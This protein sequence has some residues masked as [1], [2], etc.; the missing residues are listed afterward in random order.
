MVFEHQPDLTLALERARR[1][2]TFIA[3]LYS[4]WEK[5]FGGTVAD[6]LASAPE[7]LISLG[8]C[9][10]PREDRWYEDVEEIAAACRLDAGALASL[11]RQALAAELM[12]GAAPVGHVVDGRLLAARDRDEDEQS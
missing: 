1:S 9:R 10:R 12:A 11:L 2:A 8:L 3:S 6:A 4:P 5:A 7:S